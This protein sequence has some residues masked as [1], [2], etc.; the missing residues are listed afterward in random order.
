M[1]DK[2]DIP[3]E[4]VDEMVVDLQRGMAIMKKS[5]LEEPDLRDR[6]ILRMRDIDL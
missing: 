6:F 4:K 5:I 1:L 2:K 3:I